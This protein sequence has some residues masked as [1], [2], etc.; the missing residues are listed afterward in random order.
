M[1]NN[2]KPFLINKL[3]DRSIDTPIC[4]LYSDVMECNIMRCRATMFNQIF[5]ARH[6]CVPQGEGVQA[7]RAVCCVH[8]AFLGPGICKTL[9]EI[10]LIRTLC[11][12]LFSL[13]Q[14]GRQP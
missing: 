12:T 5:R 2:S 3:I 4:A 14:N 7:A 10:R 1:N 9:F 6:M 8:N 13:G 11:S